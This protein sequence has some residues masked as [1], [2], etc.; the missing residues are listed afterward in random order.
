M[1][2]GQ[3]G[4][5]DVWIDIIDYSVLSY[6]AMTTP[7][8]IC[9]SQ[10]FFLP[11]PYDDVHEWGL[12]IFVIFLWGMYASVIIILMARQLAN[13]EYFRMPDPKLRPKP[14]VKVDMEKDNVGSGIFYQSQ[15]STNYKCASMEN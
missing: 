5:H 11:S 7:L 13:L 10:Y 1:L 6:L 8:L 12:K 15:I 3:I 9:F 4:I 14:K 2:L